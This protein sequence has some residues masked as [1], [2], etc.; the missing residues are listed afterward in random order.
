MFRK[1]KEQQKDA[2]EILLGYKQTLKP[3]LKQYLDQKV[4]EAYKISIYCGELVE[5]I[6]D[7]TMRG[8]KRVRAALLYYSYL[9]HDGKNKK[10]AIEASI[11]M[12]LAQ[13]FLLIH[14]DIID[15][16]E[17][18]RGGKTI[19]KAYETI[20]ELRY[21]GKQNLG[22]FGISSA[23]MAGDLACA[24]SNE[25]IANLKV[26]PIYT[27]RALLELNRMY[28]LEYFGEFLDILSELRDD[29]Q[30]EDIIQ[31]H[32]LKTAPYTFDGPLKI[33]AILAGADERKLEKLNGYTVPLGTA[34]QIQDDILGMFG[35]EEK[36]GKP[37]TSDLI[38][39]KRTLLIL[40]AIENAN[41]EQRQV[42]FQ[43]LGNRQLGMAELNN[44]RKVI[45]DTGS[46]DK[47]IDLA[48]KYM[49]DA[50]DSMQKSRLKKEGKSFLVD[51]AEYM[52]KRDF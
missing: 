12:E 38:E 27:N 30:K 9:A 46:L 13:T 22:S 51:I 44:V 15:C 39:G 24:F 35:S 36:L 48:Y 34:F 17:L 6:S 1:N 40:D 45:R 26:N 10:I 11:A 23:I 21:P 7:I 4:E 25:I 29:V 28:Q 2:K 19:H 41:E 20:G 5:H 14:D 16:D 18:R 43:N 50:I 37:V 3:E 42:I 49:Q 33:G 8:G 52:V 47:S 32:Q 31:T